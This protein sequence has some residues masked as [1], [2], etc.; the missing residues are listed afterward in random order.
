MKRGS[1]LLPSTSSFVWWS[2]LF[3]NWLVGMTRLLLLLMFMMSVVWINSR[4][5]KA[6]CTS[7]TQGA[8]LLRRP[9]EESEEVSS[10]QKAEPIPSWTFFTWL[11]IKHLEAQHFWHKIITKY[12]HQT[13][14]NLQ[15]ETAVVQADK[16]HT[17]SST[18]YNYRDISLKSFW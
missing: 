15:S 13:R 3:Q 12:T 9:N 6:L 18:K 4:P 14:K 10:S 2:S 5:T 8:T 11:S 1:S 17:Y 7:Y 16:F